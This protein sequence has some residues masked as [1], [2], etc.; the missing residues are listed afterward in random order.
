MMYI[1]LSLIEWQYL[2]PAAACR[3][4]RL[5]SNR[6]RCTSRRSTTGSCRW[7][8]ILTWRSCICCFSKAAKRI[9]QRI[10]LLL[11]TTPKILTCYIIICT[12]LSS[13]YNEKFKQSNAFRHSVFTLSCFL[14]GLLTLSPRSSWVL[15]S[16]EAE[17]TPQRQSL[18]DT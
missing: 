17:I 5:S 2:H 11:Q 14:V 12:N 3:S 13:N 7:N 16:T 9:S 8:H 1:W 6:C 15:S 10:F 4:P 18:S